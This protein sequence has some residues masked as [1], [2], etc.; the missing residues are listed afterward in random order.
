MKITL[1][2]QPH[3]TILTVHGDI[4]ASN[5][6]ELCNQFKTLDCSKHLIIDMSYMTQLD[7]CGLGAFMVLAQGFGHQKRIVRL[8]KISGQPEQLLRVLGLYNYFCKRSAWCATCA[9]VSTIFGNNKHVY[10][11]T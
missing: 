5:V 10:A 3:S 1:S 11:T 9:A 4:T 6:Q 2:Y 7:S 8:I